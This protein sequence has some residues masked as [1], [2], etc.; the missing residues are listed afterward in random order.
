MER[1]TVGVRMKQE[2]SVRVI[3]DAEGYHV[4]VVDEEGGHSSSFAT[5]L[6]HALRMAAASMV[7]A[8]EEQMR[9]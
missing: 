8:C 1:E 3:S 4:F 6:D 2:F 5:D 7:V 9:F